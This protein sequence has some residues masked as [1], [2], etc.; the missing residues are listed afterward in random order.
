M[1]RDIFRN[2]QKKFAKLIIDRKYFVAAVYRCRRD[3]SIP[4]SILELM[5]LDVD[6]T[7]KGESEGREG[8]E[9]KQTVDRM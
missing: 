6:A 9:V 2:C 4:I 1:Y 5:S 3:T 8:R 7:V